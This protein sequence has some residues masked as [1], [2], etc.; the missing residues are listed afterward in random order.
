M[1]S[2]QHRR[3]H[4][5]VW[6]LAKRQIPAVIGDR[7]FIRRAW[8]A[9]VVVGKYLYIDGGE[10]AFMNGDS[11]VYQ[12]ASTLLSIDLSQDW[13]NK[14]VVLHSTSKPSNAPRLSNPSLWYDEKKGL[15]YTG[16][17]G[18]S[19]NFGDV[20]DPPPLSLWSFK[21]DGTDSGIWNEEMSADDPA[22]DS[23]VRSVGG[24]IA[25]GGD[26]ALLLGG[27][28]SGATDQKTM[29]LGSSA[30]L[31]P[32]LVTFNM[33]SLEFTNSSATSFNVN[34][35]ARAGQMQFVHSFGPQGVFLTMGGNRDYT[36]DLIRFDNI[37]V[38]EAQTRKWYSQS[39]TGN[40]PE[41]R[42]EF[43]VAG[44]NSTEGSYEIFLYAGNNRHLGP[45]AVPYDEIFIL[46]LPAFHWFKV[47]YPPQHPRSGHSC[48]ALGGS[49]IISIGGLD[50]N[51]KIFLYNYTDIY[52]S[53][54]NSTVDPFAQGLGIFNL[55]SLTWADH[56]TADARPYSQSQPI[57]NFYRDN[58]MNGSQFSTPGL[59]ELFQTTHFAPVDLSRWDISQSDTTNTSSSK[60]KSSSNNTAA[61]A[62]GI[63]GGVEGLAVI[64]GIAVFFYQRQRRKK[65]Q[66][67]SKIIS[68]SKETVMSDL[69]MVLD[70]LQEADADAEYRAAQLGTH[71]VYEIPHPPAEIGVGYWELLGM[72]DQ[73]V[74]YKGEAIKRRRADPANGKIVLGASPNCYF[75]TTFPPPCQKGS[76]DGYNA[77]SFSVKAP[78]A[79]SSMLVEIQTADDC[80]AAAAVKSSYFTVGDLSSSTQTVDIPLTQWAGANTANIKGFVFQSFSTNT[81]NWEI[82]RTSLVCGD[83]NGDG[84]DSSATVPSATASIS[85]TS[86]SSSSASTIPSGPPGTCNDLLIDDWS[87]QSR[88]TFLFYNALLLP[89]S[90][91]GSMRSIAVSSNRVTLTP[92]GSSY[93]YSMVGCVSATNKFGGIGMNIKAAAGT[94][95]QVELQTSASCDSSN[96][97]SSSLSSA[98]LGWTFDGTEKYYSIPFSRFSGL[99]T[100]HITAILFSGLNQAVTLGPLAFYCGDSGSP[101]PVAS[102]SQPAVP[103]ST[104]PATTGPT[105]FVIDDFANPD[106]NALGFWHGGDDPATYAISAGKITFSMAGNADLSWYT[107]LSGS[108][109]DFTANDN[110]YLHI[111]YTGSAAF[112]VALQQHNP[113]CNANVAPYPQTWDDVEAGRYSNSANTD[114]YIPMTHFDIDRT[115]SIGLAFKGFYATATTTVSKIELVRTVPSGFSVPS[116]IDTA[117]LYFACTRPNSFAFAIDDGDPALAQQVLQAVNAANIKVTF[118]TVGAPLLDAGNNLS[119]VYN[120]MIGRGHQMAYHSFTHPPMEG[121]PDKA[122]IDSELTQA[123]DAVQQTLNVK[124]TFPPPL[125]SPIPPPSL[126]STPIPLTHSNSPG[127]YFRPPFGTEGA[128]IRQRLAAVIPDSKFINWSVDVEDYLWALSSTPEKQLDAFKRDLARGGNLVVMHYLYPTT[129]Q[130]L[131]QFIALAKATGKQLMRVDQCMEDPEAPGL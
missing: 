100:G 117:P 120:E 102:A 90:D 70:P 82:G 94:T 97:T 116:K 74:E 80:S 55:T 14:T 77:F 126:P 75:Y 3:D 104:V 125:S 131:P 76:N 46:T 57:K 62:G 67:S 7:N 101:Y 88:L 34:G 43:C 79:G 15:I 64:I 56:F 16:F 107:Q 69:P 87:S 60:T 96:P 28:V 115:K 123:I 98:Q 27:E 95:V 41:A 122:A 103:S 33:T 2:N 35:T 45:D 130:Y 50:A 109:S 47:D 85:S 127:K 54:F 110:G 23:L 30:K 106:R 53:A 114:I 11:A 111:A 5:D 48:N 92:S 105:S 6:R 124:S 119:N 84:G 59:R 25:A 51:P 118:F 128:R 61:I 39:A 24:N 73:V 108:C 78:T 31:S 10:I 86:Q 91:D 21:P 32:G 99:D 19:S 36:G 72:F 22:L 12:Y 66:E 9:S 63:V 29:G 40:I 93:F 26:T 83:G 37:W 1:S 13:D 112:S 68:Q 65:R 89:T 44:I 71:G 17:T 18:K 113:S 121:L 4:E 52:R 129:V 38:Y 58:P 20:P 42:Q 81:G 49:Q 8:Q